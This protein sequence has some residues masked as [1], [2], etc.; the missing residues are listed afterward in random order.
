M[1]SGV[2]LG[3]TMEN[4]IRT[5]LAQVEQAKDQEN[6]RKM[7]Q[8]LQ[9]MDS[10]SLYIAFCG[11]FSAGKSSLINKLCGHQ[12]L[13]S[14]PIPT[15]ANIVRIS[16]GESGAIVV[17]RA[18]EEGHPQKTQIVP[19]SDLAAYCRDGEA[20]ETIELRYPIP[21]LG[22]HA[23]LLD[24]PGIDSTDDAHHLATE[25]ALHLADVVFYVMDYN[26]VQSEI[27][28][29]FT[30]KMQ[31][32]GKPLYLIINQVD[33]HRDQELSFAAY[34]AG[35]VEAF[36]NWH[37]KPD[38]IVYTSVKVPDHPHSEWGKLSWLLERLI[39]QRVA[40]SELSLEKSAK[41]LTK[42]HAEKVAE[43]NEPIK[44]QLRL[45][46]AADEEL[47]SAQLRSVE[48][49]NTLDTAEAKPEALRTAL[50][51]DV[52][53]LLENANI[54]PSVTRD[55]AQEYLQSRKAG[56]KVGLFAGASKTAKE[57][58][59]RL[60]ALH[61]DF[62][63]Q[64]ATQV[65]RHL[66]QG[67]LKAMEAASE[68]VGAAISPEDVRER[69]ERLHVEVEPEWIAA[70]VNQAAS[71]NGEYTLNYMKQLAAE[72]KLLYRKQAFEL[73]EELKALLAAAQQPLLLGL[74]EQLAALHGRLGSLRELERLA[75]ADAAYAAALA[76]P[77]AAVSA[78]VPA[79]PDPA[80]AAQAAPSAAPLLAAAAGDATRAALAAVAAASRGTRE[81]TQPL[82]QGA[83]RSR[84]SDAA[85]RLT[86]GAEAL[87]GLAP[88]ASISRS[89]LEK[90]ERLQRNRFTIALFGAF[91]AGKSSFANALIGERV[92]PVSPNPTTAAI[93]KIMPPEPENGWPHGTAKIRM[94]TKDSLTD[95][96]RYSLEILGIYT[97]SLPE[98]LAAIRKLSADRVSAKGKPHYTFLK[99]VENGW[100]AVEGDLGAELRVDADQFATYAANES[101]SCFVEL[102]EL[103]YSN[104][105]TDQGIVL[106]DTPGADSINARHTGVAFNYIKN[107]DAILFVT[108]YNHAFSQA[109]REFLLQL[110]RVKDS[111]E[112]DK[113]FFIVNAADLASSGE[114]LEGV[115]THVST[116]LQQQGIRHPRIYPM[117]SY[118]ALEGKLAAEQDTVQASGITAFEQDFV[119]FTLGE[120][121]DIAI[122]SGQADL[123]RAGDVLSQWIV[124]AQSDESERFTRA[125]AIRKAFHEAEVMLGNLGTNAEERELRKEIDELLYYVK[126]RATYRFGELFNLAF[127]PAV[128]REEGQDGKAI[129]GAAWNDLCRMIA[130]DLSQEVLAITL[131]IEKA[132]HSKAAKRRQQWMQGLQNEL[133][134]FQPSEYEAVSFQTPEGAEPFKATSIQPKWI[135]GFYKNAKH[136]FEG[137]GKQNLRKELEAALIEPLTAYVAGQAAWL[138]SAYSGQLQSWYDQMS[139]QILVELQEYVDGQL[140]A[141]ELPID[142]GMLQAKQDILMNLNE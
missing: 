49:S 84:L 100:D 31:E 126:Q 96:I 54:T 66:Q 55:L 39:E 28:F 85:M 128:F 1:N 9:K 44:E 36:A 25:S 48:L 78:A 67:L 135:A 140:V 56:F 129:A 107:A 34:Q 21:F 103:Y 92:L 13:P 51:K 98:S 97:T 40:L 43:R 26:H 33:K 70:Q 131:R 109:D 23:C 75:A 122:R 62:T 11:H 86:A 82:A 108:Y 117:S 79:L 2:L 142:I 105:L 15:S 113:M 118:Y 74:R 138:D 110:G 63:G 50:R 22:E 91:S 116:N 87:A 17:H 127:N 83:H 112:L 132:I 59:R 7:E 90:A 12:L 95:D 134:A 46:V 115:V 93:N 18:Q 139:K 38:G 61:Y 32:W 77:L 27:N 125:A 58:E 104:P 133:A 106:V 3:E 123:K 121:T 52:A 120:L 72:M 101:K 6:A 60:L 89:L 141:L 69:V 102:I 41:H 73:I 57:V 29:A 37:I 130:F 64:L 80:A 111:F 76:A 137:E 24:T 42:E 30:K 88:L 14:S 4:V 35:V 99:A 20:I 68:G 47:E 94:K 119:R 65:E 124:S 71:F 8:L 10:E 5:L 16:S 19:L 45:Q 136:F 53:T 114:E 81:G